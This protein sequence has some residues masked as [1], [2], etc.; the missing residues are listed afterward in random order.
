MAI[1]TL[2][3]TSCVASRSP[4]TV[5]PCAQEQEIKEAF[6]LSDVDGSGEIGYKELKITM[7][8]LGFAPKKEEF[9]KMISDVDDDGSGKI[10][11]EDFLKIMLNKS[12]PRLQG[13]DPEGLPLF[14]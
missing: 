1:P 7:R 4:H 9:Q 14:R 12:Q 13:R 8:A 3:L 10:G 2:P 6:D 11:Y 5:S